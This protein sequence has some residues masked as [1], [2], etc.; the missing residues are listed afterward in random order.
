MESLLILEQF[1]EFWR[2]H[3]GF[4]V[5]SFGNA[6]FPGMVKAQCGR[7]SSQ[8]TTLVRIWRYGH[9]NG[10]IRLRKEANFFAD[11]PHL[12]FFRPWNEYKFRGADHALTI[13][14]HSD[15]L[16]KKFTVAILPAGD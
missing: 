16:D 12:E 1:V 2:H 5:D 13:S 8:C 11:F 9:E 10:K 15:K 14:G 3:P 4:Q 6:T 7:S